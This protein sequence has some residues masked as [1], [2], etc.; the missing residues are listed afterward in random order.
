MTAELPATT[1]AA[2]QVSSPRK[3]CAESAR[4][5]VANHRNGQKPGLLLAN[6][7]ARPTTQVRLKP[8][9]ACFLPHCL[10]HCSLVS[11]ALLKSCRRQSVTAW[12]HLQRLLLWKQLEA[13]QEEHALLKA[14]LHGEI[15]AQQESE[16]A[17]RLRAQLQQLALNEAALDQRLVYGLPPGWAGNGSS[18]SS[19][20]R[21]GVATSSHGFSWGPWLAGTE[22]IYSAQ[23]KGGEA[24]APQLHVIN[25]TQTI[26]LRHSSLPFA[27]GG[28]R[29]A[30]YAE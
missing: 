28:L 21:E 8:M 5:W 10:S 3:H 4:T 25:T 23:A 16:N 27:I 14:A 13:A 6:S 30:F 20:G 18:S 15:D 7:L 12:G 19:G 24:G 9:A 29:A 1:I 26:R 17:E 2:K 22:V 11:L